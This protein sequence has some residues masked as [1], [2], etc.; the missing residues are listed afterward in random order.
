MDIRVVKFVKSSPDLRSCPSEGFPEYAFAGRS[1]VGKSSLLNLLVN[2][3]KMAKTSSTPGKTQLINHYLIN[4]S[5][6]MVDLPG[7]GFARTSKKARAEFQ[8]FTRQYLLNR[9]SLACLFILIDSRHQPLKNDLEFIQ[10]SGEN[11]IPVALIFT[12]TDKI[13]AIELSRNIKQYSHLLL[14]TWESLPPMFAVSSVKYTGRDEILDFI[15][16]TNS[17]YRKN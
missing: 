9:S 17:I 2:I 15:E 1:N 4:D 12:K 10:W 13:P 7:Y 8:N 6:Y 5:W 3:K 16:N 14:N 11:K